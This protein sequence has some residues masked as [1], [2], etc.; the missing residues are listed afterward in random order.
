VENSPKTL[1]LVGIP[2]SNHTSCN[3]TRVGR[4]MAQAVSR[5][6]VT[7]ETRTR[8]RVGSNGICG[9]RSDTVAGL[10]PSF[11]VFSVSIIPPK[12]I[13]SSKTRPRLR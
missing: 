13:Y 5:R 8:D 12:R 10:S 11:S 1:R 7:A 9:R 6:P 4:D 3:I 2:S